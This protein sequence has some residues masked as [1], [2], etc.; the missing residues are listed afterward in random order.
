VALDLDKLSIQE[1]RTRLLPDDGPVSGQV[2]QAL[3]R[4]GR[5]GVRQIY[6]ALK[7]RHDQERRERARL[8]GMLN[9]E[10]VLWRTG[11]Q[12]VAGVD[13]VGVGPLAGPVVA[14]AVMFA[15]GSVVPGV[16][17]SKR[18]DPETRAAVAERIRGHA[19]GI[20][21]GQA[22]VEEIDSVN[23]YHAGLLAMQR[24]VGALPLA[25]QH[26]L[27]DARTIPGIGM[28]QNPFTK[29][30][31]MN[32]SIAAASIIAKTHRDALMIELD[33][34]YP[35]YGFARHKG[36]STPEH[37]SAIRRYGPCPLHRMSYPFIQELRG[38]YSPAF[39]ALRERLAGSCSAARLKAVERAIA[40]DGVE[41][42][43]HE[44]RKLRLVLARRWARNGS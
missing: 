14:A 42:S 24:A 8:D 32:F 31:G 15:P 3:R 43:E 12:Y 9:F 13:E 26:V 17:D 39:Y 5:R 16:D 36:Y 28:P 23:I 27:V 40:R 6:V 25:P 4:D 44:K 7:K 10:R 11:V 20:G 18:L 2:L 22:S 37:Q 41:L 30:D 19:L 1:I 35:E 21:I 29:G 33:C 34:R 38:Q